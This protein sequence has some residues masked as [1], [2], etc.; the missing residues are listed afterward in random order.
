[1]TGFIVLGD[2]Q[3]E[4]YWSGIGLL[5]VTNAPSQTGSLYR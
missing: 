2:L 3:A 1:M 5:A 4:I